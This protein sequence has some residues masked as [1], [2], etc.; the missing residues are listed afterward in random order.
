M[1]WDAINAVVR[2]HQRGHV[3]LP[4]CR[5]VGDEVKRSHLPLAD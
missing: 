4:H 1:G 5:L 2:G 3:R